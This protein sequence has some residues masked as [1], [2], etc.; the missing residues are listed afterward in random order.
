MKRK[1]AE[2]RRAG[3][4]NRRRTKLRNGKVSIQDVAR[5]AR[6]SLGT[7]SRVINQKEDVAPELRRRVFLAGRELGF[8]PR[9]KT[10]QIAVITGRVSPFSSV[11]YVTTLV[12]L[13]AK[14]LSHHKYSINLLDV[15]NLD[16]V[17]QSNVQGVIG[18]VFDE[19]ISMLQGF[20]QLPVLTLN[21]PLKEHGFHSVSWDHAEQ[22]RLATDH[23][24]DHGHR[25]I[26]YLE[27]EPDSWGARNRLAGYRESLAK[28]GIPYSPELVGYTIGHRLYEVMSRLLQKGV[29]GL[30]NFSEDTCLDVIHLLSG[31]YKIRVPE[32]LS[33]VTM[34]NLPVFQYFNPPHT[35][36]VQP[37]DELARI[38]VEQMVRLC[39]NPELQNGAPVDIVLPNRLVSRDSVKRI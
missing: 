8:V 1:A 6:V 30:L 39:E 24:I 18:I 9:V 14:Y 25:R 37:F 32:D 31:I 36:V 27:N 10:S 22:T 23:L 7:V 17:Y 29:T 19:R 2:S 13:L 4:S 33:V 28:A 21:C 15:D 35:V 16:L 26:A 12:A 3:S 5:R 34:E 20:P 38:A 11:G